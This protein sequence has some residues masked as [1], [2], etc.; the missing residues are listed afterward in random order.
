ML[1]LQE[2][3]DWLDSDKAS[4]I[5]TVAAVVVALGLA[6]NESRR[7]RLDKEDADA[8]QAR[9]ITVHRHPQGY[10]I[11][12]H[13]MAPILALKIVKV[14]IIEDGAAAWEAGSDDDSEDG[15]ASEVLAAGAYKLMGVTSF[16]RPGSSEVN[17]QRRLARDD[18]LKCT[19]A[20][21]DAQGL[22]WKRVHQQQPERVLDERAGWRR[23]LIWR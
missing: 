19:F 8:G 20:F 13:S 16:R 15:A 1:G 17:L 11:T 14:E 5:G 9:L 22:R 3:F 4:A 7:R 23:L 2:I 21:T 10:V 12:N 6:V 18:A